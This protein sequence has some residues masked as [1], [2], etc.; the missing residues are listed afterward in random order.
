M[1]CSLLYDAMDFHYN[2]NF[3]F[4]VNFVW[5]IELN[6]KILVGMCL[7][8][9]L[10]GGLAS[11]GAILTMVEVYKRL[12]STPIHHEIR[13]GFW[14]CFEN[15][16]Y[17]NTNTHQSVECVKRLIMMVLLESQHTYEVDFVISLNW[18]LLGW[19]IDS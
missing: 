2:S 14:M 7:L 3:S 16:E 4:F 9:Y 15:Q 11:I 13:I 5:I 1:R 17:C 10:K 18:S 12:S 19:Q 8:L 6:W